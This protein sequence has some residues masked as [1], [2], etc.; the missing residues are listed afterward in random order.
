MGS[1]GGGAVLG[2]SAVVVFYEATHVAGEALALEKELHG[3]MGGA[4]PERLADQGV[5]DA[6]VVIVKGDVV[7]NVDTD[8]RSF[9][10]LVRSRWKWLECR[11]VQPLIELLP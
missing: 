4:A 2:V 3:V 10:V 11:A 7:V 6:I 5:R 8:I 1:V 9:R